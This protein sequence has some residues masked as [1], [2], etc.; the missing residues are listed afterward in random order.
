MNNEKTKNRVD[1]ILSEIS[2]LNDELSVIRKNCSHDSYHIGRWSWRIGVIDYKRF[3]NHCQ[4]IVG[5]PSI[6][7]IEGFLKLEKLDK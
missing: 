3:C 6:E 4:E 2:S 7:E 1:D 5:K